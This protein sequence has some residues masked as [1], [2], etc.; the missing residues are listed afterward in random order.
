MPLVIF[1]F[2]YFVTE[3]L[4]FY[5]VATWIGVGWALLALFALMFIGG[6]FGFSQL[7][8]IRRQA[9]RG[10][11]SAPRVAGDLGLTF[12]GVLLNA[13]PGFVTSAFGLLLI[14]P[15][16]RAFFRGLAAGKLTKIGTQVYARSRPSTSYGTFTIDEDTVIDEDRRE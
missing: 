4:A 16:T 13:A 6:A 9:A 8:S 2:T 3:A 10:Q 14:F 11:I 1:L 15:P 5:A 7:S 12:L